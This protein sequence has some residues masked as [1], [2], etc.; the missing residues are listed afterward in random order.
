MTLETPDTPALCLDIDRLDAN[1]RDMVSA[2][3]SRGVA[4]RPH[5]KCHKSTIIAR[6]LVDAGAVGVTCAKLGEAEVFAA[7]GVGDLLIANLI[8]GPQKVR[9][10]VRLRR[11]ADPVI[12]VDHPDQLLPLGT[13]LDAAGLQLR[14]LVEV[15]IGM[16]RVGVLPGTAAVALA[17]QVAATP[18]LSFQGVMGYEG[19]L[20]QIADLDEKKKLIH[21]SLDRLVQTA[22]RLAAGGFACP[23][24]SCGGTG[25]F[26]ITLDHPGITEFQAGGAIFMD[27]FYRQNCQVQGL[28]N[29]LTIEAT[30]VSCP[31]RDRAVIDAGRK[32]MDCTLCAPRVLDLPG[33][34]VASLS[35]EH[36]VLELAA[37]AKP[38]KIGQ[39]IRLIPG[40]VDLTTVL[41]DSFYVFRHGQCIDR[42][43]LEARGRLD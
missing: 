40:Y 12:C 22:E 11:V 35:A 10:L 4:W 7:G 39:R 17:Q 28:R 3:E 26:Q 33:V 19:H 36:G 27:Q 16:Q 42:W 18:G 38:L 21:E 5:A 31:S 37:D 1:I 41:H 14:V 23:I 43:S 8:V 2:S 32:T 13:A 6:R 24:V 30:V 25:S 15:D 20:L 34:T 29:A 9:R